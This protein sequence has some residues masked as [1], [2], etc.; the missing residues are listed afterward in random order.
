MLART[1]GRCATLWESHC[2]SD[3]WTLYSQQL[4]TSKGSSCGSTKLASS[5]CTSRRQCVASAAASDGMPGAASRNSNTSIHSAAW[6]VTQPRRLNG[7]VLRAHT[8][9]R[10]NGHSTQQNASQVCL[11]VACSLVYAS[12]VRLSMLQL[13]VFM[14]ASYCMSHGL[15]TIRW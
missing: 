13:R 15:F 5:S 12:A 1:T 8:P 3:P 10:S 6:P 11:L 4:A 2:S 7:A 14:Q 9:S